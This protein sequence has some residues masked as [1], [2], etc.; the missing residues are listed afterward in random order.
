M[1]ISSAIRDATKDDSCIYR[2]KWVND[3]SILPTNTESGM[4]VILHE[5]NEILENWQP[6]AEDLIATDWKLR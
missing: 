4:I 2:E 1:D 5:E 6:N 3:Y